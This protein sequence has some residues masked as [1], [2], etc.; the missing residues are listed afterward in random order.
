MHGDFRADAVAALAK[1][2]DRRV[3]SIAPLLRHGCHVTPDRTIAQ[4][5]VGR[6]GFANRA[7]LTQGTVSWAVG[8]DD[9][10]TGLTL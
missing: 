5:S 8:R 7:R 1:S 3:G 6:R 9:H 2:F 10:G 4:R